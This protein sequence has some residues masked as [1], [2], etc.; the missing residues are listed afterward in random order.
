MDTAPWYAW[1]ATMGTRR[2]SPELR[3]RIT[4][5]LCRPVSKPLH[6]HGQGRIWRPGAKPTHQLPAGR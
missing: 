3:I 6:L 4:A 2:L 1:T 5:L